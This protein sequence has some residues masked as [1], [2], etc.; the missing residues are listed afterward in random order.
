LATFFRNGPSNSRD[1]LDPSLGYAEIQPKAVDH[2]TFNDSKGGLG[3][4]TITYNCEAAAARQS[5]RTGVTYS[6]YL[7]P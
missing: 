7:F 2:G 4:W 5:P 1:N 6:S 3:D